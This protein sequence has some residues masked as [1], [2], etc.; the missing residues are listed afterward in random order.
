MIRAHRAGFALG[1]LSAA[2]LAASPAH[3][4][5]L[6]A[7]MWAWTTAG[8][9]GG[10][11]RSFWDNMVDEWYNEIDDHGW[12]HKDGRVVD[13]TFSRSPFC[14]PDTGFAGCS[15]GS[16]LDDADAAVI[17]MHGSDDVDH[18]RG[19]VRT[20]VGGD[21]RIDA[22]GAN[23]A[24]EPGE[25]FAG[26]W[27]LE[28]LHFSS[29]NSMDDDNMSRVWRIFRDPDD[30]YDSGAENFGRRLHQAGGFH[31]FMWIGGCCDDQYE[32]F[33]DDAFDVPM[34][35]AWMD[36]MYVTGIN[37]YATQCPVAYA[38]GASEADCFNRIDNEQYDNIFSDPSSNAY[39]CYYAY[40][41][42]DPEGDDPFD[43]GL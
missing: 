43:F 11:N 22:E 16:N 21:C 8:E 36:N 9:C 1:L 18:W 40:D 25:L 23:T 35:D 34:K 13:G 29:C 26:D 39:Y 6:E 15:D 5:H 19:L 20:A 37:G 2:A 3:A 42:C 12:Y 32:D 41:Q 33:A 17:A 27:D 30:T 38:V 28:F 31:G 24:A 14:D 10:S 7:R 4:T